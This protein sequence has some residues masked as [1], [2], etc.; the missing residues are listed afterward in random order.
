MGCHFLLQEIFPT[1][2]LNPPLLHWQVDSLPLNHLGSP[3]AYLPICKMGSIMGFPEDSVEGDFLL[4]FG[5]SLL[6]PSSVEVE[7]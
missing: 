5:F 6:F 7:R 1:Q 2:G 4:L 3:Q